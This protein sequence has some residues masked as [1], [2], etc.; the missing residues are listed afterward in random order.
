MDAGR[1]ELIDK[2]AGAI[3]G[4]S[5][6]KSVL[7]VAAELIDGFSDGF[8]WTGFYLMRGDKL[9]VGPYVGPETPHTVIELDRGICG[10]AAT[11]KQSIVVDD[12]KAD[13]RFLACS[14]STRS[15]IVVPLMDGDRCLGEIDID[16][17]QPSFFT[18]ADREM[19]EE[20]AG[21]V[22]KRL[23]ELQA[24]PGNN[25]GGGRC[26]WGFCFC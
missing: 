20:V 15:E 1:R 23:K 5:T 7:R 22:V 26:F 18:D 16:S 13:P 19:L 24:Q 25:S 21:L 3:A 4:Q 14:T 10:A 11:S 8:N 12:V 2:V 6:E 9:E 17:N